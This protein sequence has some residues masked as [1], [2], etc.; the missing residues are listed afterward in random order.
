[1]GCDV[2][3][4]E[5]LAVVIVSGSKIRT[6]RRRPSTRFRNDF[7]PTSQKINCLTWS[8]WCIS[9]TGAGRNTKTTEMLWI[10]HI[11]RRIS[12]SPRSGISLPL[13][14]AKA[15]VMVLGPP[16]IAWPRNCPFTVNASSPPPPTTVSSVLKPVG[17]CYCANTMTFNPKAKNADVG[18]KR[19]TPSLKAPWS[20][21]AS[22]RRRQTASWHGTRRACVPRVLMVACARRGRMMPLSLTSDL[23]PRRRPKPQLHQ[24][25][26][27]R[28]Q[29]HRR[30]APLLRPLTADVSP[31]Y[32]TIS[33]TSK[34]W[35]NVWVRVNNSSG[36][37][38]YGWNYI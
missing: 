35:Q 9:A 37:R 11:M 36:N 20:S 7:S 15:F 8:G 10:C 4:T 31:K 29:M 27:P 25:P 19:A 2:L 26:K 22:S 34:L 6:T 17:H 33:V 5:Q 21:T 23:E 3:F 32:T 14:I 38:K 28:L 30:P 16:S 18:G 1:M 24:S 12:G 13:L